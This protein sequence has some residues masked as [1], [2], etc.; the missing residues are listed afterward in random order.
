M[1]GSQVCKIL[2]LVNSILVKLEYQL[3]S[4]KLATSK[5]YLSKHK[6]HS[7]NNLLCMVKI[8][9]PNNILNLSLLIPVLN[10]HKITWEELKEKDTVDMV[11]R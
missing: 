10:L 11:E 6:H 9:Q 5:I 8:I 4:S 1:E 7:N 3:Q 2:H